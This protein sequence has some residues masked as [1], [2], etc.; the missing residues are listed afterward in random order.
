M[1]TIQT[2]H[3]TPNLRRT[4]HL[5]RT[6][7][8]HDQRMMYVQTTPGTS[9]P[10]PGILL[11][12][13]TLFVFS[14]LLGAVT[15]IFEPNSPVL[16]DCLLSVVTS[17]LILV[18][19]SGLL[20]RK[21]RTFFTTLGLPRPAFKSF[22]FLHTLSTGVY[23]ALPLL[24]LPTYLTYRS[25]GKL[26]DA[27]AF[28]VTALL[29]YYLLLFAYGSL[30]QLPAV[31][32][33]RIPVP[34]VS[35]I[36][37]LT[38]VFLFLSMTRG[39]QTTAHHIAAFPTPGSALASFAAFL[40]GPT[41]RL[42]MASLAVLSLTVFAAILHY[43]LAGKPPTPL[44][45]RS[46]SQFF[47]I[48]VSAWLSRSFA[49]PN[50]FG[51][52]ATLLTLHLLRAPKFNLLVMELTAF[53]WVYQSIS[54]FP[55]DPTFILASF[56]IPTAFTSAT[57]HFLC[58]SSYDTHP[59]GF[60]YILRASP[61]HCSR[62]ALVF[63]SAL[64]CLMLLPPLMWALNRAQAYSL[65]LPAA[66]I[67]AS[68]IHASH[69]LMHLIHPKAPLSFPVLRLGNAG[70]NLSYYLIA[71]LPALVASQVLVGHLPIPPSPWMVAAAW[72]LAILL[73]TPISNRVA[74]RKLTYLHRSEKADQNLPCSLQLN[75]S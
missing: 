19:P 38:S 20:A 50:F 62:A 43:Q 29:A 12:I 56:F 68:Q 35:A 22:E 1:L 6:L 58:I 18:F 10:K 24:L 41:E 21:E 57:T 13:L 14:L 49:G 75:M 37:T 32:A 48:R 74:S 52:T 67:L 9:L 64:A 36:I 53:L 63:S 17:F 69:L 45:H 30:F 55:E 66:L 28:V 34:I 44:S 23:I 4:L 27:F 33:E 31:Q 3:K 61:S 65:A 42:S 46:R 54:P 60:P 59:L 51:L 70:A 7:L 39:L 26:P 47:A 16:Y 73:L 72:V 8:L 25:A 40:S 71:F 2:P 11:P 5:L 15:L